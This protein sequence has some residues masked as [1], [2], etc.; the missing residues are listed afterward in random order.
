MRDGFE[1]C[2]RQLSTFT[3]VA[4]DTQISGT[5]ATTLISKTISLAEADRVIAIAD[6]RYFAVDAPSGSVRILIDGTDT[7]STYATT[8]WGSSDFPV[9]HTFSAFTSTL[10]QPGTHTISFVASDAPGSSGRFKIGSGSGL[11]VLVRPVD[12]I[13]ASFQ[14]TPSTNINVTTYNPPS[15]DITEGNPNRPSVDLLNQSITAAGA[16]GGTSVVSLIAGTSTHSCN[17]GTDSGH[18]DA[19]WGIWNNATCQST[20]QAAWS[21]DDLDPGAELTAPMYAHSI[22]PLGA[23]QSGTFSF[24]ASELAFGSDQPSPHENGV[25]YAVRQF[26]MLSA[27]GGR[28]VGSASGGANSF[29]STY[30]FKCVATTQGWPGCPSAGTDVVIGSTTINIPNG[31][32]GIVLFSAKTRIQADNADAFATATLGIKI[33]GVQVGTIGDQQLAAG[34]GQSSRTLSAMYLSAPGSDSAVLAPGSHTVEVFINVSGTSLL[35]TS[36]PQDAVLTYFD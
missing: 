13:L 32:D 27:Y 24:R 11:G 35:H 18:G 29:C 16:G 23:G 30:T 15:V 26:G 3:R 7:T 2:Q 9:Q 20:L 10:L 33:D 5:T 4:A 36:V 12:D 34:V 14:S 22:Y 6:G 19:L 21:V 25:C 17:S 1:N 28:V 8:D 31:H